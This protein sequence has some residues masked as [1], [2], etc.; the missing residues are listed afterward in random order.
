MNEARKQKG[1]S[2]SDNLDELVTHP[3]KLVRMHE[4]VGDTKDIRK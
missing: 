2:D 3:K 1:R 4:T